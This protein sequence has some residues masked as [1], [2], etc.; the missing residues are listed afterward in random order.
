MQNGQTNGFRNPKESYSIPS[1]PGMMFQNPQWMP[2]HA[3]NSK[4]YIFYV[5]FYTSVQFSSDAQSC[6]ALCNPSDCS[7][8][9]SLSITNSR[10]LLKLTSTES[11]M[12]SNHLILCCPLL[13]QP[14][15]FPNSRVFPNVSSSHQVA[16][17]LKL[18]L[19]HQSF[20]WMFR[21]DLF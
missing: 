5:F 2:K 15:I 3:V 6:P 10:S 8:Q 20:Q 11:V 4:S 21:T 17:V 13:L 14:L 12:P 7:T 9:A 1:Y 19:Q 18:Q 16:K